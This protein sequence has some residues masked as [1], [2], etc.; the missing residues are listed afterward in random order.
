MKPWIATLVLLCAV[1][2]IVIAQLLMKW[3][4]SHAGPIPNGVLGIAIHFAR[5]LTNPWIILAF[6]LALLAAL[7]W[8]AALSQLELSYASP[9]L[10]LTYVGVVLL[11]SVCFGEALTAAKLAGISMIVAGVLVLRA[12]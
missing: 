7:A 12:G 5:L 8:M 4:V 11:S 1:T 9:F 2:F 3:Q 10:A 6:L